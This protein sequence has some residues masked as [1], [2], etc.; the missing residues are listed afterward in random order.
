[1]SI[2]RT[3]SKVSSF[4]DDDEVIVLEDMR[5]KKKKVRKCWEDIVVWWGLYSEDECGESKVMEERRE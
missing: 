4:C 5:R 3:N 1:L 2:G